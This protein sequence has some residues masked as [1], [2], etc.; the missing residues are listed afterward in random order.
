MTRPRR[1]LQIRSARPRAGRATSRGLV[2]DGRTHLLHV[3]AADRDWNRQSRLARAEVA[4]VQA[5]ADL[6]EATDALL[7]ATEIHVGFTRRSVDEHERACGRRLIH[8]EAELA[9]AQ[10]SASR[11]VG[12]LVTPPLV[13]LPQPRTWPNAAPGGTSP[14]RAIRAA[15]GEHL[16]ALLNGEA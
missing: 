6:D 16:V 11:P 2:A 12:D 13:S 8:A 7:A 10:R 15:S 9:T 1:S 4:H 14:R 3:T 5:E